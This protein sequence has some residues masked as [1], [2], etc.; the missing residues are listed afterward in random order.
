MEF[1]LAGLRVGILA[2]LFGLGFQIAHVPSRVFHISLAG[3][4]LLTPYLAWQAATAG[5]PPHRRFNK[6]DRKP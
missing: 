1:A 2:A 6:K 4:F 3:V 5:A